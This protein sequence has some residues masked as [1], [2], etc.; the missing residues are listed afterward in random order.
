MKKL[1]ECL[2]IIVIITFFIVSTLEIILPKQPDQPQFIMI[3]GTALNPDHIVSFW[4]MNGTLHIMTDT[5]STF[6]NGNRD[7]YYRIKLTEEEMQEYW[8]M[9]KE[10]RIM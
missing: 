10:R 3:K 9:L 4:K 5:K 7:N 1:L 6:R 8:G 2:A